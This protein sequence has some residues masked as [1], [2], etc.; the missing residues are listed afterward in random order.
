M[1]YAFI[2]KEQQK[3]ENLMNNEYRPDK[4]ETDIH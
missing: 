2:K 3:N 4:I 1:L